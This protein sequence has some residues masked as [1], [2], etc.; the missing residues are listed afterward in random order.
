MDRPE[1]QRKGGLSTLILVALAS[2][3][4]LSC[5]CYTTSIEQAREASLLQNLFTLRHVVVEYTVDQHKRPQ[6]LAELVA[7]GYLK[8]VPA[9]PLTGRSDSWVVEWSKDPKT[10]GIVNVRTPSRSISS[11]GTAYCDW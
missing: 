1:T 6:S 9:D 4:A 10:P 8:E 11:K 7:A 2:L 5:A 3:G